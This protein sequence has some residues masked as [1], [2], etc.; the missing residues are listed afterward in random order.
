LAI[1]GYLRSR[2]IELNFTEAGSEKIEEATEERKTL[3][4][5]SELEK[6]KAKLQSLVESE[7]PFL[8][9]QL[10]LSNLAKQLGVNSTVLSYVINSGFDKNFNDFVNEF[11]I[12]EVKNKL[13]SGAAENLNLLGIAL[14]SGFNSKATFNRAFKKFTGVSPKEFQND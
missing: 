8:D 1:A 3:L 9:S 7:K 6:I 4:P 11:R 13:K 14:D 5:E 10:T 12:N 2:T